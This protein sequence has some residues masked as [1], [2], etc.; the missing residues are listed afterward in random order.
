MFVR[1]SVAVI[2]RIF[3][4]FATGKIEE[5]MLRKSKCD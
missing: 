1:V 2:E 5:D 4:K 3:V